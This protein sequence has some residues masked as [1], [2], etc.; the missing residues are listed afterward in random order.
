MDQDKND[1]LLEKAKLLPLHP[2]IYKMLDKHGKIIYIGKAKLLKNRVMQYF[3]A[4]KKHPVKT[5]RMVEATHD[6]EC[7]Y[8]STEIEALVLE[9][10]WIKLH[11]PKYNIKLKDGKQYPY[12]RL[13]LSEDYARP[14]M[15]RVR[16][17]KKN[18]ADQY[19]G[20]Y[21]SASSVYDMI[22]T[23]NKLFR[24]PVCK[25]KFPRDIGAARPCL[26]FHINRCMGVCTGQI[27][28]ETY[29]ETLKK[30]E[31]FLKEDYA[32]TEKEIRAEMEREAEAL[33]FENAARLRDLALSLGKL[34]QDQKIVASPEVERDVF[35]FYADD[36]SGCLS[37][38]MIR[39]GRVSDNETFFFGADEILDSAAFS[40]FLLTFY[41]NREYLPR[42]IVINR[43]FKPEDDSALRQY[44]AEWFQAPL[45]MTYPQKGEMK[46][47]VLMAD[48]NARQALLHKR[49]QEE[50]TDEALI[51]LASVLKLET[52][53]SV[54]EAYD[55]SN[56][57]N[58]F[59]TAGMAVYQNGGFSKRNYRI[60]NVKKEVQDDYAAMREALERRFRHA[61]EGAPPPDL[62]LLDG[63]KGHVGV[64]R[65]L[66]R[67]KN[68]AVPLFGM[69]KDEYHKTR[70]LTDGENEISI[71][72]H[73][74]VYR[75]VYQI[76]EE[77]HRFT[78]RAMNR[79]REGRLKK[80]SL[81]QIDGIGAVKAKLLLK[82]F[83]SIGAVKNAT[84]EE[85]EQ[86]RGITGRDARN[87]AAYFR[88]P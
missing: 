18:S 35:G 21:S 2:G 43:F 51:G 30:V 37:V 84:A 4:V 69:V 34:K 22:R 56:S 7:V 14:R 88:K 81:E 65:Q 38:L 78:V 54:I 32:R 76:Q 62:I 60:F 5:A 1:R 20:P 72:A 36:L 15:V 85:L 87:I 68:L 13:D 75:L 40:S 45:K 80:S 10:E 71:A 77:A 11:T 41:K 47:L 24:L 52:V 67:E 83:K 79:R 50:R 82:H 46:Q 61:D 31:L 58:E 19:Y 33:R 53:P 23:V 59:I 63:G 86:L 55:I 27:P 6:F 64:I 12:L 17:D 25:R 70:T 26:N 39:R 16:A 44:I 73:P 3:Q 42:E 57:G 49:A 9:N 66:L 28:L 8:T 48:D 74:A 29:R